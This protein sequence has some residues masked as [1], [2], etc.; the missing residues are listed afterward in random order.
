M[1]W[2]E[3]V[4]RY[5][6]RG[7]NPEFWGE[8]L[9]ALS[10]LAFIAGAL[11]ALLIARKQP[12]GAIDRYH[13]ILIGLVLLIGIGSGLFHTF[14]TRWSGVADV[15][16]IAVFIF[17]YLGFALGRLLGFGLKG[18]FTG[19][20]IFILLNSLPGLIRC[21]GGPC[22][23]GTTGYFPALFAMLFLGGIARYLGKPSSTSLLVAGC[24]FAVSAAF[25]TFDFTLCE[26][27]E[28]AGQELGTHFIWHL[29]NALTLFLLL[30]TAVLYGHSKKNQPVTRR[31]LE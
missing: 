12:S 31:E 20:G 23:N 18:V 26:Y 30:R 3:Q 11:A 13:Y 17:V 10:N 25:R 4:F 16:P 14:A 27:T 15:L 2:T 9:N 24:V 22:L 7:T 6:E 1:E 19:I 5:C 8:P 28:V 21:E 29:L